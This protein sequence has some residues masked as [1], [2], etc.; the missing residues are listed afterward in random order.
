MFEWQIGLLAAVVGYLAGSISFTRIIAHFI[1]PG[2]D[3]SKTE[4]DIIGQGKKFELTSVSPTALSARKGPKAGCSASILDMIKAFLPTLLFFRL[5]PDS[6]YFL[7]VAAMAVVG[8]N[9]PAFYRFKG[10]RG[11]S[12]IFGG[13]L[14]FDWIT[15]PIA[16]L[17]S[18]LLG[19]LVMRDVFVA[20]MSFALM[21]VP[22]LWF[23]FRDGGAVH[24]G[25]YVGYAVFVT[26]L[27]YIAALPEFRQYIELKRNQDP[28]QENDF[29]EELEKTDMGRPIKYMRKYGFFKK[30]ETAV[31]ET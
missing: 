14:M 16:L 11:L 15:V 28:E 22:T 2:E 29:L 6:P 5:Y 26:T 19:L 13:V 20:Y 8:H 17:L 9:W 3:L 31:D 25:W 21:L 1:M 27:L 18:N 12:P 7:I 24:V 23:R 30:K 4:F 10:G